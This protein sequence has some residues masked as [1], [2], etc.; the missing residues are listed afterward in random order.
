[1][2]TL[3]GISLRLGHR[4]ILDQVS[5]RV[6]PGEVTALV[7][8]NGAG[9]S[10]LFKLIAGERKA[11]AG[12]IEL[13]GK[14]LHSYRPGEL[15]RLRAV[16]PQHTSLHFAYPVAEIVA[17]GRMPYREPAAHTRKIVMAALALTGAAQFVHTDYLRLSGGEQQRVQLARVLAQIWEPA[18][19][20]RLLLL[21][22][23]TASQDLA[24]QYEVLS[25]AR[26]FAGR[27]TAVFAI[28]HDLNLAAQVADQL[29][30]LKAGR[31]VAVGSVQEV[32]CPG[33]VQETFGQSVRILPHPDLP[34]PLV[35]SAMP[36]PASLVIPQS[37]PIP[38]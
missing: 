6:R 28:L 38:L 26:H 25:I 11:S 10:S 8:P 3:T 5:L 1:M 23:P 35:V 22:E 15:A 29:I 14:P 36:G 4:Q 19:T 21:D 33:I 27:G 30:F 16:L 18:A 17:L 12:S 37:Q 7:G 24:H 2:L 9:K 32:L 31:I 34:C 13:H 20:P